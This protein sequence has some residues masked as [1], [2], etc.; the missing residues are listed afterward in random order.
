MIIFNMEL[1]H[2]GSEAFKSSFSSFYGAPKVHIKLW[3]NIQ[4]RVNTT[5]ESGRTPTI[6]SFI[7]TNQTAITAKFQEITLGPMTSFCRK[8]YEIY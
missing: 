1:T 7:L 6:T 5:H 8:R 2:L 3:L 4:V